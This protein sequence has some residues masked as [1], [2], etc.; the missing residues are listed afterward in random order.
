LNSGIYTAIPFLI[1]TVVGVVAN[2]AGDR[3]LTAEAGTR[4]ASAATWW[5]S[6]TSVK[7]MEIRDWS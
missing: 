7:L 6:V 5:R 2:W 4:A 1:S 3:V